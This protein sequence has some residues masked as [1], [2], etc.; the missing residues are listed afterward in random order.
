VTTASDPSHEDASQL[1]G[2]VTAYAIAMDRNDLASLA[3]IFVPEGT[4]RVRS[5]GRPEPLGVFRGPGADGIGMI[6]QLMADLYRATLHHVTTHESTVDGDHATGTT[7]C[8]AYHMVA[9]DDGGALETLGVCYVEDFVRTPH[10]WRMRHRDAT[11]LWSQSTATPR[12][13]LLVD[14]AAAAARRR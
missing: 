6:A 4:L 12:E 14:R 10:G 9:G 3:D 7:Y 13:A 2:L 1:L 5:P 8:L 11:R